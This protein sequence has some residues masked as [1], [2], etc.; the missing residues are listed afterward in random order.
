M[1]PSPDIAAQ[2]TP[3]E[4]LR[5]VLAG[6]AIGAV[7]WLM[8]TRWVFPWVGAFADSAPCRSVLGIPATRVLWVGLFVGVPALAAVVVGATLGRRG[9]RILCEGRV[10]LRHERTFRPTP[11]RRGRRAVFIAYAHLLACVPFVLLALWGAGRAAHLSAQVQ[12]GAGQ[13]VAGR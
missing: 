7:G 11:V 9:R 10:P 4:R 12:P 1:N 3:R 13:C 8:A 6:T 2:Y 5:F